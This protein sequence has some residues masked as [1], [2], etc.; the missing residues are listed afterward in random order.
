MVDSDHVGSLAI[1]PG[2]HLIDE[3]LALI[4]QH[5]EV[6]FRN[7]VLKDHVT[8][9][10]KLLDLIVCDIHCSRLCREA[11]LVRQTANRFL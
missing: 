6:S 7:N 11:Q 9:L 2:I 8:L 5:L 4:P 10:P 1:H 3:Y